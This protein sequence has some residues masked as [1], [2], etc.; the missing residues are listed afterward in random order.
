MIICFYVN[1]DLC[2][3]D[4][5]FKEREEE[6][7]KRKHKEEKERKEKEKRDEKERK[8]KEKREKDDKKEKKKKDKERDS[9]GSGSQIS[10]GI[11]V[12]ELSSFAKPFSAIGDKFF[13]PRED[14]GCV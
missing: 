3:I 10:L 12:P 7:K 4:Q 8:E 13:T 9:K 1:T 5:Y 11:H 2:I 14:S 6:E